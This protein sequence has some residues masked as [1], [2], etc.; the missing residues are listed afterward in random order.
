LTSNPGVRIL[1][2][3]D[4]EFIVEAMQ[5]KLEREEGLIFAGSAESAD[6]LLALVES[7]RA[8]IVL[9]DMN[10]PGKDPVEAIAELHAAR[11]D[12]RA[13]AL[14]GYVREDMVDRVL[15]AGAWG[16]IAKDEDLAT[17]V[18]SLRQAAAGEVVFSPL[19][20]KHYAGSGPQR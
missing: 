6:G 9:I 15:A 7:T 12:V 18:A 3:D 8:D 16:Y 2:V 13:V 14:S 10:M 20:L 1:C 5:R 19:V 17:I 11:P 4:N